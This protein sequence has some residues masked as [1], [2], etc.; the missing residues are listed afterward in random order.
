[1]SPSQV[2]YSPLVSLFSFP[3]K[4]ILRLFQQNTACFKQLVM[5]HACL[6]VMLRRARGGKVQAERGLGAFPMARVG[7]WVLLV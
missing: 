4:K 7:V 3:L 2:N 5:Q 6:R 1:M